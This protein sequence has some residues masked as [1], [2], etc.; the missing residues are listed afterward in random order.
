MSLVMWR[1]EKTPVSGFWGVIREDSVGV[2]G[3]ADSQTEDGDV[4][5]TGG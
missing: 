1:L 3:G 4:V 2:C 5:H